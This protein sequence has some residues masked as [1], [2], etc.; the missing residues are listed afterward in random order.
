M[1]IFDK[2]FDNQ[3]KDISG[4]SEELKALYTY[5]IYKNNNKNILFVANTLYEANKIYQSI[6]CYTENV[7]FFP[8]DDFLTS[9]AIAIS[10]DLEMTRIETLTKLLED[11][12][13][14]VVT[15]LMGYLRF[16][17]LKKDYKESFIKIKKGEEYKINELINKLYNIGYKRETVVTITGEM[18]VRGYVVDLFPLNYTNPIR[19]EFWGDNIDEIREFNVDTQM[20]INK[21]DEIVI[22][23]N[24][25]F[26][27]NT[28]GERK[29]KYLYKY[30]ETTSIYNY[31]E[32]ALCIFNNYNEIEIGY[33]NIIEDIDEYNKSISL[34]DIYM[35]KFNS[36]K[37][38][39]IIKLDSFDNGFNSIK[40]STVDPFTSN[41]EQ[42]NIRLNKYL[43]DK[44][45]I[46]CLNNRYSL[47]KLKDILENAIITNEDEIINNKINLI[48]KKLN[49]SYIYND[50]VVINESTIF[51]KKEKQI[52]YK[53]NFKFGKKIKDINKLNVGDY[54]VHNVHGIGRYLGLK[55][56]EKAGVKKDYL[57]I[58]YK[59]SDKLYIPVENIDFISKY[60]SN[61]GIVPKINKLGGAEWA[62][63]KQKIKKKL[64][65]IASKLLELYAKRE[66]SIGFQFEKDSELQAV[67]ESNFE[68]TETP[69]QLKVTEEIKKDM[70]SPHPMDRLLCGDVGYGK[71]EIAF[72][73]MFKAVLSNKQ[74]ALLCPTTI[75]SNQHYN[76]ALDRFKNFP[77][78]VEVLNRFIS[79]KK[80]KEIINDLKEGKIDILI[81]THRILSNDI[82]FKNLGLLVVDEEQRFGVKHKEKIKELKN[83]ID[84]L[85]LSAT[86]IPR[87]LQMSI[88]GIR[89]L[90]LI[91]TPPTNRYPVQTYVIE[92][93]DKVIKEAIYKEMSRSG[94]VFI[95]FNDITNMDAKKREIQKLVPDAK[96]LSVHGRMNKNEIEDIMYKFINKEA[97]ILL[98]TTIIETGIDIPNVNTLIIEN[99]DRF[100]LS[101]LYQI[102]GRVGRSDKIA[103]CYLM[104]KKGKIIS[105][106]A[107]KRLD[108]I[109]EFA[110][111]GSGFSIAMRDLS[112]RGA[113]DILGSEQAGFIDSVGV[114]LYLNMLNEEVMKLQGKVINETELEEK[115]PLINI[116]TA[117]DDSYVEE[118]ELKIE[119]HKK[120]NSIDSKEKLEKIK[121]ELEDRF[122]SLNDN[123]I[124]YMYEEWFEKLA[125]NLKIDKIKQTKNSIE[126]YLPQ[127]LVKQIDMSELFV[128]V[129]SLSRM[130]RFAKQFS[131]VKIIL[132][133]IKLDK[134]YIYYL[135]DLM[136][137]IEKKKTTN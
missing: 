98:C 111:L 35:N 120:I 126:I 46:I 124:I 12:K 6:S 36:I 93:N 60:S 44:T 113:G 90:S 33:K 54:V 16:L 105:D 115:P 26:I 103:Y 133:T 135:I 68:Y 66:A 80:T 42:I 56:L 82:Q 52:N 69:D 104:Y 51:S 100:G 75:L 30:M 8:M 24:S 10:P 32:D 34:N 108:V 81:G 18:A 14:I 73:A 101:Q 21:L 61:D 78:R 72:R 4:M 1:S 57:L 102:R 43:K 50:Y 23:P 31:L 11:K 67:F 128:E 107:K 22:N 95:L 41:I 7:L 77:V 89:S 70:E 106:I 84:I 134:H 48:I 39:E 109:R 121:N 118:D 29:Q 19:I 47:N 62:K 130:F 88:A 9:E 92:E 20:T 91:E 2:M 64:E 136:E 58:E 76:Y 17:P 129:A 3:I 112:I 27:A 63:T 74:V 97:D 55:T 137:L 79:T 94:Q 123:M 65:D 127:E 99:A 28:S 87:T 45:V 114:E 122:G 5:D 49:D 13:Y 131:N 119:I 116:E 85:T 125:R 53:T 132:D 117:I 37:P 86:P 110:E 96:I 38:K 15:N 25:E 71:T 40:K 83:N 59:D